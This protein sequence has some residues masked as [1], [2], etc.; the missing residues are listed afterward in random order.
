MIQQKIR[1]NETNSKILNGRIYI[2]GE[3]MASLK[4]SLQDNVIMA[5]KMIHPALGTLYEYIGEY[6]RNIKSKK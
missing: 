4:K 6:T 1:L 3:K 2:T 5:N